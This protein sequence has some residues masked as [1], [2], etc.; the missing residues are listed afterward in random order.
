MSSVAVVL[1]T[2]NRLAMLKGAVESIRR[3]CTGCGNSYAIIVIDGG[4]TDGTLEWMAESYNHDTW[5]IKQRGPLTG[6]VQAFNLG[7]GR[8]CDAGFDYVA[9]LNDD[10]L[11]ET[12]NA[13]DIAIA[14]LETNRKLGAV[15]FGYDLYKP[16]TFACS[17]FAG[18]PYVNFGV[19]RRDAGEA[20]ARVQGDPTGRAWWNP[21]YRTYG[22][23]TEFGIHMWRLGWPIHAAPEL[24][25]RDLNAQDDLRRLNGGNGESPDS[26][27]FFQRW[28]DFSFNS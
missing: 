17:Y 10:M 6:A 8:A 25:V 28:R 13:L 5:P 14:T 27:L 2:Y 11:L 18:K 26:K 21:I 12:P 7:F 9:H 1:G 24:Q 16:G 4:S 20:V 23:D 22:A 19:I 3:A 15:A